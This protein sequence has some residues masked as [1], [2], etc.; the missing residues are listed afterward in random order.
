MNNMKDLLIMQ[1]ERRENVYK[2]AEQNSD[3][4]YTLDTYNL[5]IENIELDTWVYEKYGGELL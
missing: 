5:E 2:L 4:T 3:R 1:M